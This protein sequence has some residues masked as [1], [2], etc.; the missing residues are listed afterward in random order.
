MRV[1]C[2]LGVNS[3][4]GHV[5]MSSHKPACQVTCLQLMMLIWACPAISGLRHSRVA[6]MGAGIGGSTAAYFLREELGSSVQLDM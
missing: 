5:A 2:L 4:H 6:I 3:Q 1:T